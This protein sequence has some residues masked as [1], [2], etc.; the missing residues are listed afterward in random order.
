[1]D[2]KIAIHYV[3]KAVLNSFI[4]YDKINPNKMRFM[5]FK[6]DVTEKIIIGVNRQNTPDILSHPAIGK[7]FLELIPQSEKKEKPQKRCQTCHEEGR[8]KET[9]YQC[10]ICPTHPGLCP[11]PCFEK[12][13]SKWKFC[14]FS[15]VLKDKIDI[16][17]GFFIGDLFFYYVIFKKKWFFLDAYNIIWFFRNS[18]GHRN[19]FPVAA[20]MSL[21]WHIYTS[22]A[23]R[24]KTAGHTV[25]PCHDVYIR[26]WHAKG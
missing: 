7:H 21:L 11:A 18:L 3:E 26:H 20:R 25:S 10:K 4:L 15:K 19:G 5:N 12:F 2:C 6:L 9:R 13:H 24:T 22:L 14:R 8:R 23:H 17:D 1:M 16:K